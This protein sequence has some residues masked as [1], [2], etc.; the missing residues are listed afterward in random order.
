MKSY[1]RVLPAVVLA[2][3]VFVLGIRS[4]PHVVSALT[5][6][7][8]ATV[9]AG[10][11]VCTR[12][13]DYST[14]S[15][16]G[17]QTQSYIETDHEMTT[18]T[19]NADGGLI[20]ATSTYALKLTSTVKNAETGDEDTQIH[21]TQG[22]ASGSTGQKD[23]YIG[24]FQSG[25]SAELPLGTP[26]VVATQLE[27][28]TKTV[29]G[30]ESQT[31]GG[32][33]QVEITNM[34]NGAEPPLLTV[35]DGATRLSGKTTQKLYGPSDDGSRDDQ[36]DGQAGCTWNLTII[37]FNGKLVGSAA[38]ESDVTRTDT[39]TRTFT[40]TPTLTADR[41]K[42][43]TR[44]PTAT[45]SKAPTPSLTPTA[46]RPPCAQGGAD[47]SRLAGA[48]HPLSAPTP[49]VCAVS[50]YVIDWRMPDRYGTDFDA[51]R[52]IDYPAAAYP[53]NATSDYPNVAIP[54]EPPNWLVTLIVSRRGGACDP[55]A[56][57]T[58]HIGKLKIVP[59]QVIK[60]GRRTCD[61]TYHFD[62]LATY[63]V[64]VDVSNGG[65][66]PGRGQRDV[67][68]KD[69]LIVGLGDSVASGEGDPDLPSAKSPIWQK[70]QCHRSAF[71][72]EAMA[73]ARIEQADPHTSVTFVHLA[74][75]GATILAG[76]LGDYAGIEPKR[77]I[78]LLPQ[79]D[80]M[81]NSI[82]KRRIDA[83]VISVGANDIGFG[84]IV[85]SCLQN[86]VHLDP[87]AHLSASLAAPQ[88]LAAL[89][90]LYDRLAARLVP[91][92]IAPGHIFLTQ[93]FDPTHGAD[94]AIC[95]ETLGLH[96]Q[97]YQWAYDSVVQP[98]NRQARAAA[99]RHQWT[100]VDG[101][102]QGFTDHGYCAGGQSWIVPVV[103]NGTFS[104]QG[105]SNGAFH[106]NHAGYRFI[107]DRLVPLLDQAFY[108]AGDP[109]GALKDPPA[110][111]G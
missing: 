64:T 46:T 91:A 54:I 48:A 76:L 72:F 78:P 110:A 57:Y 75:S 107:A 51:D 88:L 17:A 50:R 4:T 11:V 19:L 35:T 68:V 29:D 89:P 23:E 16:I 21:E 36:L 9:F 106:P 2:A 95:P 99:K 31:T 66:P 108:I 3:G 101:I 20:Q 52:L 111:A 63:P 96:A 6:Q 90:G 97:D 5:V 33:R 13:F 102:A 8:D 93:Y 60:G 14:T 86:I 40:P 45:R 32:P 104:Q 30:T 26:T 77:G 58:W 71:S 10:T 34:N 56:T 83:L 62:K 70:A 59:A 7:V 25:S 47:G 49:V 44:T 82:G 94:G 74:C 12:T 92:P 22:T 87:C 100:F 43:P 39:P 38:A 41:T 53:L 15:T 105:N 80:V 85:S 27:T 24:H 65:Y 79:I 69:F 1:T 84:G 55:N 37:E 67:V 103:T 42:T 109:K 98:L 73:A 61:F 28:Y 18:Y 81:R